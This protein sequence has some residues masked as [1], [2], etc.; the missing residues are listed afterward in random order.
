M[1][2][3]RHMIAGTFITL[4]GA[5]LWGLNAVVSKYLMGRG[6]DTMWMVNFRM[7]ASGFVLLI[8]A[9]IKN[10]HGIF[11]IWKDCGSVIR[12]LV[13][14]LFAFGLCQPTYYVSIDYSNA[15]IASA[16]Q[17]TAPVFV[18]IYVIIRER[19]KPSSAELCA[20][21][22][23]ITGSFLISTHGDIS[24][25]AVH[26]IALVSGLISALCCALYI[27][28]PA[29]LIKR[30]GTFETVGWGLFLGGIF[31]A[32]FCRLWNFPAQW[33]ATLIAGMIF[34]ILPGAAF[35]F[36]LFLYG[37][38]IVGPVRGGVYNLFE[39]VTA[40]AASVILLSQSFHPTETGGTAAILA[41]IAILTVAKDRTE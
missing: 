29:D 10:P 1:N 22:L 17:Q 3:S 19:R 16:I 7:I 40:L 36:A 21:A 24:A 38:S 4:A 8:F 6:I 41:G 12:L 34:I 31:I 20:L 14:A 35:A 39:P 37:T 2:K 18:L 23:V 26:P 32:P 28:L 9:L 25:L 13:I 11:D 27:T 30:Y 5:G 15:G 33:D